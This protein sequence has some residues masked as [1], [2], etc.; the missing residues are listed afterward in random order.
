MFRAQRDGVVELAQALLPE[1]VDGVGD[2]AAQRARRH[3]RVDGG[4]PWW[5]KVS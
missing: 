4:V 1:R 5:G 3:V 2:A